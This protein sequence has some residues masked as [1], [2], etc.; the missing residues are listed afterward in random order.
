MVPDAVADKY[1]FDAQSDYMG[2]I[3]CIGHAIGLSG[4][5]EHD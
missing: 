2:I 1:N 3:E 4:A 5:P